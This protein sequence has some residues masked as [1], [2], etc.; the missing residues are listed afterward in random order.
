MCFTKAPFGAFVF[1]LWYNYDIKNNYLFMDKKAKIG[2]ALAVVIVLIALV[3]WGLKDKTNVT[4]DQTPVAEAT[5]DVTDGSVNKPASSTNA[6][7]SMSYTQALN[8]YKDRKI[9]FGVDCAA[10]PSN[11]TFRNNTN[12]M[13]DN[14]SAQSRTI[15]LGTTYTVKPYGFKIIN[16][17]SS[18]LPKTILVDCGQKQN[19]ATIL[20]QK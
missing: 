16:L 11:M 14:R 20:L 15:T 17:S 13:L 12:I 7:S 8:T 10:T 18:T 5:E 6:G 9:Q 3:V 4:E 1:Y 19:I 2:L